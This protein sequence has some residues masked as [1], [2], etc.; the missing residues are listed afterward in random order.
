MR[1]PLSRMDR[2]ALRQ[3][4]AGCVALAIGMGIFCWPMTT[5]S[6][7]EPVGRGIAWLLTHQNPSGSWGQEVR[8]GLLETTAA[9]DS[10]MALGASSPEV[11]RAVSWLAAQPTPNT[12]YL[13]RKIA[14]FTQLNQDVGALVA[15]LKNQAVPIQGL[16]PGWGLNVFYDLDPLDTA[17]AFDALRRSRATG[18][19]VSGILTTLLNLLQN[20]DGGWGVGK[21]TPSDVSVTAQVLLAIEPYKLFTGVQAKI[22]AAVA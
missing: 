13:A 5:P 9:L 14:T 15:A 22:D 6:N 18:V 11:T 3:I 10:L 4:R 17:L 7:P 12:D 1:W 16:L 19:N 8:L 21:N 2:P 20:A